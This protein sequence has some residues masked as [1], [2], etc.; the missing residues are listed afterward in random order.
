MKNQRFSEKISR[1]AVY[2][3]MYDLFSKKPISS[4]KNIGK[5][6]KNSENP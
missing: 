2:E 6:V 3:K 5:S 4:Q 1:L